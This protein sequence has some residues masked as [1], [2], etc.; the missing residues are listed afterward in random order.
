MTFRKKM[1]EAIWASIGWILYLS[2]MAT[3][4]WFA[5]GVLDK[6]FKQ[7]TGIQQ[8]EGNIE[9]HP[10][11]VICMGSLKYQTDFE[12]VY[13]ITKED[14]FSWDMIVDLVIGENYLETLKETVNLSIV[15]TRSNGQCYAIS[16]SRKIDERKTLI[17]MVGSSSSG[18]NLPG[19]FPV[20]FTSE[21]NSYGVTLGDWRDGEVFSF[22]TSGGNSKQ[23]DLTVEKLSLIH[24]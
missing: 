8:H 3:S 9:A 19:S 18:Y 13:G 10:T 22:S 15:Y 16:T 23:I 2:L 7:D 14:G 11:I 12:I 24:I 1:P 21:M 17:I 4:I 6:F 5:W 20:I